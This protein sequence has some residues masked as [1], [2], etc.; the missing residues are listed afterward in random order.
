MAERIVDITTP[1]GDRMAELE[2]AL[3]K[4][5]SDTRAQ[6]RAR[7]EL[8]GLNARV[9][10]RASASLEKRLYDSVGAAKRKRDGNIEG[11]TVSFSRHGIF[12]ERGVGKNRKAGSSAAAKNVQ[13]WLFPVL[14][15]RIEALA[16]MLEQ[17][18]AD[19]AAE[20]VRILIPG[21]IDITSKIQK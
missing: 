7:L 10:R 3:T 9:E 11:V 19:I 15:G 4:F 17:E 21:I 18:F 8:L 14:E 6:L 12:V 2:K 1:L 20:Q 13:Q 16:D 5:N